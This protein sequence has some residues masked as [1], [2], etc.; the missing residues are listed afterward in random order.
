M[1]IAMMLIFLLIGISAGFVSSAMIYGATGSLLLAFL[2]YAG[3]GL[4][5]LVSGLLAALVF[6][7]P[8]RDDITEARPIGVSS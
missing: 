4:A 7:R 2:A 3:A 6:A 5:V 1:V 8:Q